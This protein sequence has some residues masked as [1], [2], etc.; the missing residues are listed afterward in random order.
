MPC[1]V[2]ICYVIEFVG[3][4]ICTLMSPVVPAKVDCGYIFA[5]AK[6]TVVCMVTH[7]LFDT[8]SQ[9]LHSPNTCDLPSLSGGRSPMMLPTPGSSDTSDKKQ[10]QFDE[11]C[12]SAHG[13]YNNH[14][15]SKH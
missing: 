13:E 4:W 7:G 3:M 10:A 9:G 12:V 11:Q 5:C 1:V 2:V 6:Y 14:C 8:W 15:V